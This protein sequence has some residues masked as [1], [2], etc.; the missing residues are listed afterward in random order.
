MEQHHRPDTD[1][2]Y[3]GISIHAAPG[4]HASAMD[5]L[6]RHCKAG[7]AVLDLGCGSGAFTKRLQD[8]GYRTTSVDLSLRDFALPSESLEMDLNGEF[9]DRL[10]AKQFDA[11]VALEVV[12]HLENPLHFLR[13]LKRLSGPETVIFLSFPNIYMYVSFVAFI[14]DGTFGDWSPRLYWET[15]HQT[16]MPVWLFEEHLRKIGLSA[17]EKHY[18]APLRLPAGPRG[19]MHRSLMRVLSL[20]S[21]KISYEARRNESVLFVVRSR[22]AAGSGGRP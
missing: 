5:I 15:G 8:H 12:E 9:A 10:D 7:G 1:E 19:W 18:C 4:L 16:V 13:Q 3:G 14:Q 20:V 11:I 6:L 17:E 22:A 21:R 2:Q